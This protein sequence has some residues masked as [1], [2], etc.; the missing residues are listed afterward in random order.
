MSTTPSTDL[1][2]TGTTLPDQM[3]YAQALAQAGS[4]PKQ[5]RQR[6]ADLLLAMAYS[7]ALGLSLAVVLTEVHVVDGRPSMSAT[8]MASLARRAGHRVRTRAERDGQG[9]PVAVCE[10]RRADDPDYPF[11]TRW[12][13]ERAE[14]AGLVG[15]DNWRHYP[16][17]MLRARAV[18]EAV[19]EACPEVMLGH[20]DDELGVPVSPTVEQQ[21]T[22]GPVDV[23]DAE[24]V[25]AELVDYEQGTVEQDTVDQ[26]PVEAAEP[27]LDETEPERPADPEQQT[28]G[29]EPVP[30]ADR[31]TPA[32]TRRMFAA[33]RAAG[34]TGRDETL[35]WLGE[36]VGRTLA[37]STELT[38]AEVS[39]VIDRLHIEATG[40]GQ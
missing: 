22:A 8:L 3:R 5:Y 31:P 35:A 28:V 7:S 18:A 39:S 34:H 4:L 12:D 33:L 29:P 19:R 20:T 27:D 17:Q 14:R 9:R 30:A 21:Q 40:G 1:D 38:A 36:H 10:V 24:L 26:D 37:S 2:V 6:P 25:D 15:K 11:V 16:E 32:A 13:W 23:T